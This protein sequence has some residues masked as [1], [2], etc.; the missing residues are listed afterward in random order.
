MC[1]LPVQLWMQKVI[2]SFGKVLGVLPGHG[3]CKGKSNSYTKEM[4]FGRCL[5]KQITPAAAQGTLLSV[6]HQLQDKEEFLPPPGL[7][8]TSTCLSATHPFPSPSS[9]SVQSPSGTVWSFAAVHQLDTHPAGLTLFS[10]HQVF[11][12]IGACTTPTP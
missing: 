9:S 10:A 1:L 3:H 12:Q 2:L 5:K 6:G 7:L 4:S 8:P 11:L